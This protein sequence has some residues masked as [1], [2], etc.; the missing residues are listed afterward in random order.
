VIIGD[1]ARNRHDTS[2]PR[3]YGHSVSAGLPIL[4]GAFFRCASARLALS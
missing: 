4:P 3:L 1:I 2:H